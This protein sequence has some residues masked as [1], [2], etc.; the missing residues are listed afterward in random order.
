MEVEG[1]EDDV[2]VELAFTYAREPSLG[3]SGHKYG[4]NIPIL[5]NA[6]RQY[7]LGIVPTPRAICEWCGE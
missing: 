4:I 3:K 2:H 1:D 7:C 6:T 5:E